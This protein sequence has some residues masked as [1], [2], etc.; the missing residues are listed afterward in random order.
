[1]QRNPHPAFWNSAAFVLRSVL[2]LLVAFLLLVQAY[3]YVIDFKSLTL[4]KVGLLVLQ[5]R[6]TEATIALSGGTLH[7]EGNYLVSKLPQ[8][9]YQ[10]EVSYPTYQTWKQR[11]RI[12]PGRSSAYPSIILF[13]TNP[14]VAATQPATTSQLATPLVDPTLRVDGGELWRIRKDDDQLVTRF[15]APIRSARLFDKN[16]VLVTIG[17]ELHVVDIDG[18]NDLRL[19][20]F[21]D[22]RQRRLLPLD[23]TSMGVLDGV[24]VTEFVIR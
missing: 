23:Q 10:L 5:V 1:M 18:S 7:K 9:S 11:V 13:L 8:G 4:T 12:E 21:S 20:T 15:S 6:P 2:T 14:V 22:G 16:H 24:E 19:V 17:R 3:G